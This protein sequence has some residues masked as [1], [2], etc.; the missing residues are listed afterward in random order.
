[1]PNLVFAK[2]EYNEI[3][4]GE[5]DEDRL[6]QQYSDNGWELLEVDGDSVIGLCCNC[7]YPV[8]MY[9]DWVEDVESGDVW[10]AK[11]TCDE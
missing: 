3:V 1:M 6:I 9:E 8:F 11:C 7:N 10:C 2:T 5:S 4:C